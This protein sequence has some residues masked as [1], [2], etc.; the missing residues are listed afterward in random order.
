MV[1]IY[2]YLRNEFHKGPENDSENEMNEND[3]QILIRVVEFSKLDLTFDEL[4]ELVKEDKK[5]ANQVRLIGKIVTD[6]QAPAL[7]SRRN[8]EKLVF[9]LVVPREGV[10]LPLYF[11]RINEEGLIPKFKERFKKGDIIL[12]EG[13]LQTEKR[14][15]EEED[16]KKIIR[17]SAIICYGFTFIDND[18]ANVFNPLD[19]SRVAE[20]VRKIVFKPK[21]NETEA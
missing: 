21:P 2:G 7:G 13:F 3:R 10:K 1:E 12:L 17:N 6:L 18:S 8:P 5:D 9:R 16:K 20:K 4:I 14:L 19:N 11:C 15:K